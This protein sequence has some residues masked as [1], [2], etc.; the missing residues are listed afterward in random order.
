MSDRELYA[1]QIARVVEYFGGLETVALI[2]NVPPGDLLAW[3]SGRVRP[4]TDVFL[5]LVDLY[6]ECSP[7]ARRAAFA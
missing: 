2:M 1:T 6:S 5:R 3:A 4:P 7:E